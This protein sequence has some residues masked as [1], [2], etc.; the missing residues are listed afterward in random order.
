[1]IDDGVNGFL[2]EPGDGSAFIEKI[3]Y[4]LEHRDQSRSMGDVAYKKINKHFPQ[5][6]AAVLVDMY[7]N[8]IK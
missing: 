2:V 4:L 7:E 8:L 5:S 6:V 1:M 3:M